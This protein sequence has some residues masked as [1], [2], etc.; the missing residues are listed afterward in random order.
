MDVSADKAQISGT[1]REMGPLVERIKADPR[2]ADLTPTTPHRNQRISTFVERYVES[3]YTRQSI[4]E[5]GA[6]FQVCSPS[7]NA[8]LC[9]LKRLTSRNWDCEYAVLQGM[10]V[11]QDS[12]NAL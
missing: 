3:H 4:P 1:F 6:A 7:L 11:P 8:P 2:L 12:W 9:M 5:E 10:P